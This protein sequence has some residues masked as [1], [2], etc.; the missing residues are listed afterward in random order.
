MGSAT[1]KAR[2][3]GFIHALQDIVKTEGFAGL[4]KGVGPNSGRATVLAATEL[5]TYDA[6]K[7]NLVTSGLLAEGFSLHFTTALIA[8]FVSAATS[9][10]FDVVK[11]RVMNQ[12]VGPDGKG[13]L[14]T[15]MI[16]CFRYHAQS[17]CWKR[18]DHVSVVFPRQEIHRHGRPVVIVERVSL[19]CLSPL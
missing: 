7:T 14:F 4:Y 6:V 10:P 16:D 3:R 17:C 1:G 12:P 19:F 15:G 11:S 5:S 2:Y 8:G 13:L 9:S 18:V